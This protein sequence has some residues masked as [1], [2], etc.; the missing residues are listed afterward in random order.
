M[1]ELRLITQIEG[2][3]VAAAGTAQTD[4]QA[5]LASLRLEPP[6]QGALFAFAS[7][8]C[9]AYRLGAEGRATAPLVSRADEEIVAAVSVGVGLGIRVFRSA[10]IDVSTV[11]RGDS[12]SLMPRPVLGL[13]DTSAH[14]A[15][16]P[17]LAASG[18]LEVA[19]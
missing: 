14:K 2:E 12:L 13:A 17:V 5:V 3:E 4:Q 16:Q 11:F 6:T 1:A 15:G 10:G 9:G 18:G 8:G 19:W 7:V